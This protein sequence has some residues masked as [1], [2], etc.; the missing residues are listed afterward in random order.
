MMEVY[1][2][3]VFT[4]RPGRL[5]RKALHEFGSKEEALSRAPALRGRAPGCVVFRT[6]Y[7]GAGAWSDPE[8]CARFGAVPPL[9]A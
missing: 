1:C 7:I 5:E 8:V 2:V 3:A 6:R 4:G 9:A